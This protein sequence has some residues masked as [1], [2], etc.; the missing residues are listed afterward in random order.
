MMD[1][2]LSLRKR[3]RIAFH[4]ALCEFCRY[5]KNQMKTIKNLAKGLEKEDPEQL[6]DATLK[7]DAKE[8]MKKLMANQK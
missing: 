7:S 4:I 8:R 3:W 5:Y 1:H 6:T 2:R